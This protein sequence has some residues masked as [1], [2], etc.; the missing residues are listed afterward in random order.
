VSSVL[1]DR[2]FVYVANESGVRIVDLPTGRVIER[3]ANDLPWLLL[4]Q[5]SPVW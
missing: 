2:A 3:R 5:G 1:R 4:E